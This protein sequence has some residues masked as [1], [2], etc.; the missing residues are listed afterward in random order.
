MQL[1]KILKI[2]DFVSAGLLAL[3]SVLILLLAVGIGGLAL[4]GGMD[5]FLLALPTVCVELTVFLVL[6]V[7]AAMFAYTG[8]SVEQGQGRMLRT[9]LAVLTMCN[10]P[11][12]L[13]SGFALWVMWMNEESKAVFDNAAD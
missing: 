4:L 5:A 11:G 12:F 6:A 3:V 9:V 8:K 7:L 10:C 13:F 1:L 2:L